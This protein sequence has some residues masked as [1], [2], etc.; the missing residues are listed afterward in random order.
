L[1]N[2]YWFSNTFENVNTIS[3]NS[4]LCEFNCRIIE[5]FKQE[6]FDNMNNSSVLDMYR[7]LN[8]SLEYETY[9]DLLTKRELHYT[10]AKKFA[11]IHTPM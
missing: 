7:V 11:Y 4:F 5:T 1:L 3:T 6:W 2:D 9:L 8:T 10:A